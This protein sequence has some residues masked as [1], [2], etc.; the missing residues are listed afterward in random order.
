MAR[1]AAAPFLFAA[2]LVAAGAPSG[3]PVLRPSP[4]L[5][6]PVLAAPV[7]ASPVLPAGPLRPGAPAGPV[8]LAAIASA[9]IGAHLLPS[10]VCFVADAPRLVALARARLARA[11]VLRRCGFV[12][13]SGFV[14]RRRAV[15]LGVR[16]AARGPL[17]HAG[18]V[19]TELSGS[20]G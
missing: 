20:G 10:A 12:R 9:K 4:V 15:S 17:A 18:V 7:L 16:L 14:G 19:H 2:W 5:A 1:A 8:S 3:S 11:F 13:R 6:A